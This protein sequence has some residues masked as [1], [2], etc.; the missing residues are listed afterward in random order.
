[1]VVV[2]LSLS[3]ILDMEMRAG[4]WRRPILKIDSCSSKIIATQHGETKHSD[5]STKWQREACLSAV[6]FTLVQDSITEQTGKILEFPDLLAS[7][8]E[9]ASGTYASKT[10]ATEHVKKDLIAAG[11]LSLSGSVSR[12]E[13]LMLSYAQHS[14]ANQT[15]D[16]R[17]KLA[18]AFEAIL[19]N[20]AEHRYRRFLQNVAFSSIQRREI[21]DAL[22]S[23]YSMVA[24]KVALR[25][26]RRYIRDSPG[27][28]LPQ[29][30]AVAAV[31]A[32]LS[33]ANHAGV[34]AAKQVITNL[35]KQQ[36]GLDSRMCARLRARSHA[37]THLCTCWHACTCDRCL[38]GY[39]STG[40]G[41]TQFRAFAYSVVNAR[42]YV[43]A[44]AQVGSHVLVYVHECAQMYVCMYVEPAS[45]PHLCSA[46]AEQ[47]PGVLS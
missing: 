37:R 9:E 46:V 30:R 40:N 21:A 42:T 38:T 1:V 26:V 20:A 23:L 29:D 27:C 44:S 32:D 45:T 22:Y 10:I 4:L 2:N 47:T 39:C 24:R 5:E 35:C 33:V 19:S 12:M 18:H 25:R 13:I 8:D 31:L 3:E 14:H 11:L 15:D 16:L 7:V 41:H 34:R 43:Y 17:I 28:S 6:E 36:N